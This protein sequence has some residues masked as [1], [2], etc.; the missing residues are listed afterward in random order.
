[1][2]DPRAINSTVTRPARRYNC[3]LGGTAYIQADLRDPGAI[4]AHPELRCRPKA[5]T[6]TLVGDPSSMARVRREAR[7][8]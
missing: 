2:V 5:V 1:M 3:W 4:L 8:T 7:F 6:A